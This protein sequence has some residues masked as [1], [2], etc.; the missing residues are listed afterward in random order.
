MIAP[1]LVPPKYV[2]FPAGEAMG[3]RERFPPLGGISLPAMGLLY[4]PPGRR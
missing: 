3:T 2:L 4:T 1:V